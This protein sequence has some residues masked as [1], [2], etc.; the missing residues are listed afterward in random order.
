[1]PHCWRVHALHPCHHVRAL[2]CPISPLAAS[3]MACGGDKGEVRKRPCG[4]A[5][6]RRPRPARS[7]GEAPSAPSA[8]RFR[9]A[10]MSATSSQPERE[11]E[12]ERRLA[13][14][15]GR[16]EGGRE[17]GREERRTQRAPGSW[18]FC[19]AWPGFNAQQQRAAAAAGSP[20]APAAAEPAAAPLPAPCKLCEQ[21]ARGAGGAPGR[22]HCPQPQHQPPP[23]PRASPG[24]SRRF[25]RPPN[26]GP[27]A[28]RG[29]CPSR[30]GG[31]SGAAGCGLLGGGR[32][33]PGRRAEAPTA[34]PGG[35]PAHSLRPGSG[36]TRRAWAAR[37]DAAVPA[38]HQGHSARGGGTKGNS[39]RRRCR[40]SGSGAGWRKG[41]LGID[42]HFPTFLLDIRPTLDAARGAVKPRRL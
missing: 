22:P 34:L 38:W 29:Q 5:Q 17:G 41:V 4:G 6:A 19:S 25:P 14:G 28:L 10:W 8:G 23:Q 21:P 35:S 40:C 11:P 9:S 18:S 26:P 2:L 13:A 42:P 1:M 33:C 27:S 39:P 12:R 37:S 3:L 20:G 24:S 31:S 32:R 30:G 15:R 16:D 36:P 7:V